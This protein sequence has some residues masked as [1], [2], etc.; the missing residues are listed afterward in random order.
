MLLLPLH[1][2]STT[3]ALLP[4]NAL[5]TRST[6]QTGIY[7]LPMPYI[8]GNES[9]GQVVA[10]GDGVKGYQVGDKVAVSAFAPS[11]SSDSET[12]NESRTQGYTAGGSFAEYALTPVSKVAKLPEG[13]STRDAATAFLQGLTG[14]R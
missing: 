8:L 10:L 11:L 3:P 9:A 12:D 4:L 1:H 13:L 5:L 7:K 14:K 2:S 6:A